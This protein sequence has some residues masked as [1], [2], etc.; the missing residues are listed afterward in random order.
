MCFALAGL[1]VGPARA[2]GP[3]TRA[4]SPTG[5]ASVVRPAAAYYGIPGRPAIGYQTHGALLGAAAASN[6]SAWA[7]GHA[8]TITSAKVLMLHWNGSKWSRVTKPA[9]LAGAGQLTAI[10]VVSASDAWAVGFTGTPTSQ[11]TLLLHWNGTAWSQV[12]S[13]A[14]IAGA[15]NA[16]TATA[17]SGWAVG[18]VHPVARRTPR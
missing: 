3:A 11:R 2:A 6:S 13:A 9:A 16:V 8:G 7:V 18:D 15:L 4:G 17:T 10:M 14:P 12:T 1:V 5:A